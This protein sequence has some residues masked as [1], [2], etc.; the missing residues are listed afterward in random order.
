MTIDGGSLIV[1][2]GQHRHNALE[3]V[4]KDEVEGEFMAEVP[5][6]EVTIIVINHESMIKTRRIFSKVNGYAKSTSKNENILTSE[7]DAHSIVAR[8]LLQPDAPLDNNLVNFKN[9]TLSVR[10]T[11]LTTLSVVYETIKLI[12]SHKNKHLDIHLRP[13]DEELEEYYDICERYWRVL[14]ENLQPFKAASE[15]PSTIPEMRADSSANSLLFKPAAQIA[16]FKGLIIRTE[17]GLDFE[18]AVERAN[19]IDWSMTSPI[20]TDIIIRQ[21]GTIDLKSDA[22]DRA[23]DL[24]AYL[25]AEDKM[26]AEEIDRLTE[27]YRTVRGNSEEELPEFFM[28]KE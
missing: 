3:K 11:Q 10:S 5:N 20:W 12:L 24:T 16:F 23:A 9:N 21:N 8:K 2:D 17:R 22:R 7:D 6:D 15:E 25:I 19:Q 4:N 13:S 14:M 18:E 26:T 27:I 28:E 1:L